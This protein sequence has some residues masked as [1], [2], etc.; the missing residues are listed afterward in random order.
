MKPLETIFSKLWRWDYPHKEISNGFLSWQQPAIFLRVDL[1]IDIACPY[2]RIK[3][4]NRF[5]FI[6]QTSLLETISGDKRL[7][8]LTCTVFI[9]VPMEPKIPIL[10]GLKSLIRTI[11]FLCRKISFLAISLLNIEFSVRRNSFSFFTDIK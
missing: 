10:F 3:A 1:S 4:L 5:F 6:Y 11:L 2:K 8:P 9:G 7:M